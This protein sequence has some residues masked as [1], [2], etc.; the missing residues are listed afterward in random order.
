MSGYE[1]FSMLFVIVAL[2]VSLIFFILTIKSNRDQNK[3]FESDKDF[4]EWRKKRVHES[5][6]SKEKKELFELK[7]NKALKN[8]TISLKDMSLKEISKKIND[9]DENINPNLNQN[10][11]H[12]F[13]HSQ[14]DLLHLILKCYVFDNTHKS[15][16]FDVLD[17][18]LIESLSL[19][20]ENIKREKKL[21]N[22]LFENRKEFEGLFFMDTRTIDTIF[23]GLTFTIVSLERRITETRETNRK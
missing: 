18:T 21:K 1:L 19:Y 20:V 14:I 13:Y 23:V 22:I 17:S 15:I 5:K 7:L 8:K 4:I 12:F 3:M 16:E 11:D 2:I 9:T 6:I 10:K